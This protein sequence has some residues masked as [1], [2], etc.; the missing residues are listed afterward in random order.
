MHRPMVYLSFYILETM[1]L[2]LHIVGQKVSSHSVP[3][4]IAYAREIATIQNTTFGGIQG[5]SKKPATAWTDDSGNFAGII[6]QERNWTYVLVDGAGHEVPE[7]Q[8]EFVS[9]SLL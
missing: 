8:P 3:Y 4:T 9:V 5:F 7:F 1:T 6:H 2:F